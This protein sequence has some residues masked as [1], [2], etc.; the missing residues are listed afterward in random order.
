MV[1]CVILLRTCLTLLL[2]TLLAGCATRAAVVRD[3]PASLPPS[4]PVAAALGRPDYR[5]GPSDLLKVEVFQVE[6]LSREVRVNNAGRIT[7]P[8]LGAIDAAGRTTEELEAVIAAGYADRYL[9]DPQVSVSLQEA[10]SQRVT[11]EGAVN[12][13]GIFPIASRL[14]LLQAIALAKGPSNV[15]DE[16]NVVVFRTVDGRRLLARFDLK[17]IR[18][19]VAA[20]PDILGEDMVVVDESGGKVWLR[21]FIELTPLIGVWGVFR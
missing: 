9:Q 1:I 21:R 15:A 10:A 14:T 20:D 2:V 6:N 5:I 7:L 4:D 18:E 16:R 8:L 19:G 11:V 3:G 17:A 13:P 12:D